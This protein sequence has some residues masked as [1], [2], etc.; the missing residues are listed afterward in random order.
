VL[1]DFSKNTNMKSLSSL[2]SK[3]N[4]ETGKVVGI[5]S[6]GYI[7]VYYHGSSWRSTCVGKPAQGDTVQVVGGE[8]LPLEVVLTK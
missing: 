4:L 6:D 2:Q 5:Y 3:Q 8:K 7:Q 1:S